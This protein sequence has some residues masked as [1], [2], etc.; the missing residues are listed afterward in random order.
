MQ[1]HALHPAIVAAVTKRATTA[2]AP[3]A[4]AARRVAANAAAPFLFFLVARRAH[5]R[6]REVAPS[7]AR[8]APVS[9]ILLLFNTRLTPSASCWRHGLFVTLG[10]EALA[11]ARVHGEETLIALRVPVV[12]KAVVRCPRL[13]RVL[14]TEMRL[15]LAADTA[16]GLELVTGLVLAK[17][18]SKDARGH[19]GL[20]CCRKRQHTVRLQKTAAWS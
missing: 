5:P 13:V 17:A 10:A 8:T 6:A 16:N 9:R 20:L 2:P 11:H 1:S 18:P 19:V 4:S 12:V 7:E 3:V 14:A 15:H